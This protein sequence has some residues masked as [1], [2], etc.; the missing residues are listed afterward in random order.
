MSLRA[1]YY[2]FKIRKFPW[3]TPLLI[4][5]IQRKKLRKIVKYA[6][7]NV[8][9][10]HKKFDRANVKPDDIRSI[11]DL[12]KIPVTTKDEIHASLPVELVAKNFDQRKC[13]KRTTSGST[14]IPLAIFFDRKAISYDGAHWIRAYLEN[15][16]KFRDKMAF[17]THPHNF[18]KKPRIYEYFGLLRRAYISI[19]DDPKEQFALLRR[20]R[21][22]AIQSYPS[23][24][25]I[26]SNVIRENIISRPR[27][28]FTT[29]E[30]LDMETRKTVRQSFGVEPTDLYGSIEF[31]LMAWQC[32][33]H[34]GYHIESDNLVME[35]LDANEENVSPNEI[36]EIVC[37][38]LNNYA[39]P[40]IRY[41][42]G[43]LGIYD[44]EQCSCGRGLPLLKTIEG[45]AD[46]LIV[47]PDD[48]I[49][50]PR[51]FYPDPFGGIQGIEQFRVV[52]EKKN[53][54]RILIKANKDF[55]LNQAIKKGTQRIKELF[56]NEM[57]VEFQ[58]V[59]EIPR[60]SSGKM[61]KIVSLVA[62]EYWKKKELVEQ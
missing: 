52:Q 5:K 8:Y 53:T 2:L 43:D 39:M 10:Y 18:Q 55:P 11:A 17:I 61:R 20:Y 41:K 33:N 56:G 1:C 6:Y 62:N 36:G 23:S 50:S 58:L 19:F 13:F 22:E 24:L 14:G 27:L 28:I 29:S 49:L 4:E 57:Q 26:L 48:R 60:D 54:L 21:P 3:L 59:E 47:S 12:V 42:I 37:T 16:F 32:G 7:E 34:T 45:R 9:F 35:F 15:G 31:G 38:G 40:L 46:D 25:A 30:L 44:G 51:V